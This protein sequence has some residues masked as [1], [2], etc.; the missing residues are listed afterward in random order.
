M[1][2]TSTSPTG[3]M[4]MFIYFL[5]STQ[6]RIFSDIASPV[7]FCLQPFLTYF[8]LLR[9]LAARCKFFAPQLRSLVG[10]KRGFACR[11]HALKSAMATLGKFRAGVWGFPQCSPFAK[12]QSGVWGT[13][14]PLE[15]ASRSWSI[16]RISVAIG[17]IS[18]TSYLKS[19]RVKW[20]LTGA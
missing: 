14:S 18:Q 6:R 17:T 9:S 20:Y 15:A 5:S 1:P 19:Q 3:L 4:R 7:R 12:P 13:L 11:R 10:P 16:Y 2:A 8:C